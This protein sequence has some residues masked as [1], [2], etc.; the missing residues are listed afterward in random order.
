MNLAEPSEERED[1]ARNT[2]EKGD[3]KNE[4]LPVLERAVSQEGPVLSVRLGKG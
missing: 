4:D 1:G 2:N 3:D